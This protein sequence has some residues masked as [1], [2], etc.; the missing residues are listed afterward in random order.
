MNKKKTFM[1]TFILALATTLL[2]YMYLSSATAQTAEEPVIETTKVVTTIAAVPAHVRVSEEMLEVKEVPVDA[3]HPQ[4]VTTIEAAVGAMTKTELIAGEQLLFER[5]VLEETASTLSYRIPESM[6]AITIP[7]TETMGVAGYVVAGD[8]V[9]IL[10]TYVREE[11]TE[12]PDQEPEEST[13]VYTQMQNVEVL[14]TGPYLITP[15]G[16]TITP[17]SLTVLVTP[18]QAEVVAYATQTGTFHLSLR[19]PADTEKKELDGYGDNNFE[20]W[21]ER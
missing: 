10:V 12:V 8:F 17:T 15:D 21:K 11:E 14:A 18:E 19:N 16:E 13:N 3:V 1:T 6:R 5:L 7:A 9:D 2:V 20:T 4:A